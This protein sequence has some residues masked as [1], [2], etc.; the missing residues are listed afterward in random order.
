MKLFISMASCLLVVSVFMSGAFAAEVVP[1][2]YEATAGDMG[3]YPWY[4]ETGSQLTDG[5]YGGP[6]PNEPGFPGRGNYDWY[7]W[8][9]WYSQAPV[10]TFYFPQLV[11]L[12]SISIFTQRDTM[13][14]VR[15]PACVS[16]DA[17]DQFG[18]SVF[19]HDWNYEDSSFADGYRYTLTQELPEVLLSSVEVRLQPTSGWILI[20]EIDFHDN[21]VPEASSLIVLFFSVGSIVSMMR[22]KKR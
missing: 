12:T 11:S 13:P 2:S 15:V 14:S 20:S 4:D 5:I 7:P 21:S 19:T 8:V 22:Y 9:G 17:R 16:I 10:L 1:V 18:H 6:S 3:W